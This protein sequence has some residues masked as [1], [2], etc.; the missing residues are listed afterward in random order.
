MCM[1]INPTVP[2]ATL[3]QASNA[4]A[5]SSETALRIERSFP[6][7]YQHHLLRNAFHFQEA[8]K[9]D[10][11]QNPNHC[12]GNRASWRR[13]ES[14]RSQT[15]AARCILDKAKG[16]DRRDIIDTVATRCTFITSLLFWHG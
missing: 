13:V 4:A 5:G 14:R 15:P 12:A 7:P 16:D 3:V 2:F 11:G 1:S 8:P 6:R 9:T 10:E